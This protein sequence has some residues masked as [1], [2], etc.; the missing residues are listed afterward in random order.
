MFGGTIF[1]QLG[2]EVVVIN[3]TFL[4]NYA[5]EQGGVLVIEGGGNVSIISSNFHKNSAHIDGGMLTL[6]ESNLYVDKSMFTFN[7]AYSGGVIFAD[8]DNVNVYMI[9]NSCFSNNSVSLFG[10]VIFV[11]IGAGSS[12]VHL[13]NY[14]TG[15]TAE[16][17]AAVLFI[18]NRLNI[19]VRDCKLMENSGSTGIFYAY[20]VNAFFIRCEFINNG[21]TVS[22]GV[23]LYG[24]VC[25]VKIIQTECMFTHNYMYNRGVLYFT[26]N[27]SVEVNN[28]IFVSN[29]AK[30]GL[31][32]FITSNI[33]FTGINVLKNNIGS[34]VFLFSNA[35]FQDRT[36]LI[37]ETS[38]SV[39]YNNTLNFQEGGAITTV[40]S[41]I[42]IEGICSLVYNHAKNGGAIQSIA[43]ELLLY[44]IVLLKNNTAAETGG[45]IYLYQSEIQCIGQVN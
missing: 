4:E 36:Y 45:G 33:F 32:Y 34:L 43:S 35:S 39:A 28:T 30:Q 8:D 31:A 9:K 27:S 17:K 19:T 22:E 23:A 16:L 13:Q 15:N 41:N 42:V 1:A 29:T 11:N 2:T 18:N 26:A 14:F 44:G 25:K 3:S 5:R 20:R 40:Q 38:Y 7:H 10:G 37:N 21:A 24:Q 6:S 12:I